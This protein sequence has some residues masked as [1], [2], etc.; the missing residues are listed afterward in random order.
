M[1]FPFW[2]EEKPAKSF[3]DTH[4][5]AHAV[6]ACFPERGARARVPPARSSCWPFSSLGSGGLFL[7]RYFSPIARL[8]KTTV[9]KDALDEAVVRPTEDVYSS[10]SSH[11]FCSTCIAIPCHYCHPE[12]PRVS[13]RYPLST[14]SLCGPHRPQSSDSRHRLPSHKERLCQTC[15]ATA[16]LR[17]LRN[18]PQPEA[19]LS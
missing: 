17:S 19:L 4:R 8:P 15:Y 10:V 3:R 11:R 13:C 7:I 6:P 12:K 2:A 14:D 18:K 16:K 9:A 5:V 1:F